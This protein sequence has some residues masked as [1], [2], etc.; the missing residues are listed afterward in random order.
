MKKHHAFTL[1]ELL[2][3]ISIIAV[4]LAI[5]IP[6]LAGARALARRVQCSSRLSGIGK[7]LTAY[8][9]DYS[10]QLPTVELHQ[11]EYKAIQHYYIY[12]RQQFQGYPGYPGDFWAHLGCLYGHGV[13]DNPTNFYCPA[14]QG[15]RE[16][17]Q[18]NI[19]P[20]GV[21][22]ERSF[23]QGSFLKAQKGYVYWPMSKERYTQAEWEALRSSKDQAA[24]E[25][26]TPGL[27]RTA[28]LQNELLMNK[29]IAADYSFHQVKSKG[30][31]GWGMN[32]LFP[33][34]HVLFQA[35]PIDDGKGFGGTADAGKGMWHED[36]QFPDDMCRITSYNSPSTW[37]DPTEQRQNAT[38]KATIVRFMYTLQP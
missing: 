18:Q 6:S 13:I 34:G 31:T 5:L 4:L 35:Q 37:T 36:G 33:D 15:W 17:Y 10:T 26:Y 8:M 3:V 2:V 19:G 12:K 11:P 27:P 21:W 1:V 7:A 38:Y 29:A 28:T 23:G 22:G 32:A 30:G 16:D 14:A 24:N 25:N 9:S 20:S